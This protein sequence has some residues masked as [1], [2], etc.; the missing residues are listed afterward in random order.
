[1]SL[2]RKVLRHG[3]QIPFTS[4]TFGVIGISPAQKDNFHNVN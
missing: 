3:L 1:M 4:P 2:V